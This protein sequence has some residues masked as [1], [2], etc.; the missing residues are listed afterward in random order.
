MEWFLADVRLCLTKDF[1]LIDCE[2]HK[3]LQRNSINYPLPSYQSC[4]TYA[5]LYIQANDVSSRGNSIF[6]SRMISSQ[7]SLCYYVYS[8]IALIEFL[9]SL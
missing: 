7:L 1:Q 2:R 3:R 8:I 9:I 5:I 4:P 6:A